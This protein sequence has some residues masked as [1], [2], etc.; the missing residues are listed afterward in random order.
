MREIPMVPIPRLTS[1]AGDNTNTS[2]VVRTIDPVDSRTDQ[3]GQTFRASID[4][5]VIVDDLWKT[6]CRGFIHPPP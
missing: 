3:V 6:R 4:S 2:I 5:D 1:I